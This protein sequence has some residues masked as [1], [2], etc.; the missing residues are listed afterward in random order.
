[1]KL[2][3]ITDDL[4]ADD[5]PV[6]SI[7]DVEN[8]LRRLGDL[9]TVIDEKSAELDS[10]IAKLNDRFGP[11]IRRRKERAKV[12]KQAIVAFATE[13]RDDLLEGTDG[14]TLELVPGTVSFVKGRSKLVYTDDKD[15]IIERLRAIGEGDLIVIKEKLQKTPLKKAWDRLEGHV[16]GLEMKEGKEQ[17]RV[18]ARAA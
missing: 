14:K 17:V 5:V 10:E 16:E 1:M 18:E 2:A 11:V 9:K 7:D 3:P 15:A 4:T 13:H 8:L 12:I 6:E